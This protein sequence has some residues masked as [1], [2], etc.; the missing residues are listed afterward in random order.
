MYNLPLCLSDLGF[1]DS[2]TPGFAFLQR[3][4]VYYENL[5]PRFIPIV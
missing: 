3:A 1:A 2:S 4:N 5:G